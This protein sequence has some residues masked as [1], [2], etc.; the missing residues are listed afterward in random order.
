MCFP[1]YSSTLLL[2]HW[3]GSTSLIRSLFSFYFHLRALAEQS[4]GI[5]RIQIGFT[6]ATTILCCTRLCCQSHHRR[7]M[8]LRPMTRLLDKFIFPFSVFSYFKFCISFQ[9]SFICI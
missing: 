4:E 3:F 6:T 7:T 5:L 2:Q 8:G 9:N 1:T